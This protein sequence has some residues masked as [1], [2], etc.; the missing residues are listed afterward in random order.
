MDSGAVHK[1]CLD[2]RTNTGVKHGWLTEEE[3]ITSEQEW[4]KLK[5]RIEKKGP[6]NRNHK[7]M[8]P[9]CSGTK[10]R[11]PDDCNKSRSI[12]KEKTVK[13]RVALN[14]GPEGGRV[15][16]QGRGH[17]VDGLGRLGW[18]VLTKQASSRG[19]EW[20]EGSSGEK[21]EKDKKKKNQRGWIDREAKQDPRQ[22]MEKNERSTF[23]P[24]KKKRK[25]R[26]PRSNHGDINTRAGTGEKRFLDLKLK[27]GGPRTE[28]CFSTRWGVA[29]GTVHK[30]GGKAGLRQTTGSFGGLKKK[31]KMRLAT[32]EKKIEE[33]KTEK[34][35]QRGKQGGRRY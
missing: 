11:R 18:K 28:T 6:G 14:S 10:I 24:R 12:N 35:G 27:Q 5:N 23:P 20:G 26:P 8:G 30:W 19:T 29:A 15:F 34:I 33:F 4:K 9:A 31:K 7:T 25:G 32:G 21:P 1:T 17:T 22:Q 13:Y 16:L 3:K 2:V